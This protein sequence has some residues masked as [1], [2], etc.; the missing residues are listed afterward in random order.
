MLKR[1]LD[2]LIAPFSDDVAYYA[3]L[4]MER[5]VVRFLGSVEGSGGAHNPF[6]SGEYPSFMPEI[7]HFLAQIN[8]GVN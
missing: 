7:I 1:K 2:E 8:G 3:F 6:S 4:E 5:S